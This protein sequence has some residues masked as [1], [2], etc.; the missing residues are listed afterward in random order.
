MS[1]AGPVQVVVDLERHAQTISGQITV[2]GACPTAFFGWLELIDRLER[3]VE[4][5]GDRRPPGPGQP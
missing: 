3:A 5:H 4:D 2:P 1:S